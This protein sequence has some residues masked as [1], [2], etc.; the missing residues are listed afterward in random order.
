[1]STTGHNGGKARSSTGP[2]SAQGPDLAPWPRGGDA[3]SL[4]LGA[5][6]AES[7]LVGTEPGPPP[8]APSCG[9]R[10]GAT[11]SLPGTTSAGSREQRVGGPPFALGPKS[12]GL[13]LPGRVY[14]RVCVCVAGEGASAS[15]LSPPAR[16]PASVSLEV[17]SSESCVVLGSP[18]R[19]LQP[20]PART[21]RSGR[22]RG[23]PQATPPGGRDSALSH[24]ACRTQ[25]PGKVGRGRRAARPED[26]LSR[27]R[28]PSP[29]RRHGD[30]WKLVVENRPGAKQ[31]IMS[32]VG[33][34]SWGGGGPE[35]MSGSQRHRPTTK[36]LVRVGES[37]L[38]PPCR[39]V[40]ARL[41]C[42]PEALRSLISLQQLHLVLAHLCALLPTPPHLVVLQPDSP[43]RG[44][45]ASWAECPPP[46]MSHTL[47]N[48][49]GPGFSSSQH[50]G[51]P[52][53]ISHPSFSN[54]I[55]KG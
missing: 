48:V 10:L 51:H 28:P 24:P 37:L 31:N 6:R 52:G 20:S 15:P 49:K 4:W 29:A 11:F 47:T 35:G 17:G 39:S 7:A 12:D 41:T 25:R 55:L 43:S 36:D 23:A 53:C 38:G 34:T 22:V 16:A 30:R 2:G 26:F 50:V 19:W 45:G 32:A 21:R 8:S 33:V 14:V 27:A 9:A 46:P 44:L 42:S 54:R 1:M 3:Q 18:G 5:P 40:S 13:S